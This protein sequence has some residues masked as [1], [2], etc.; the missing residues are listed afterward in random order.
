MARDGRDFRDLTPQEQLKILQE[1]K[2]ADRRGR[3]GPLGTVHHDSRN[4]D[5]VEQ[6]LR[7]AGLL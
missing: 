7:Q 3:V 4:V 5:Q 2:E 6:R 1:Q